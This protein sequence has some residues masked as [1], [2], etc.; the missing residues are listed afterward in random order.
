MFHRFFPDLRDGRYRLFLI[1]FLDTDATDLMDYHGF[2][3]SKIKPLWLIFK[4]SLT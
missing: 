1:S 3:R 2:F 4:H